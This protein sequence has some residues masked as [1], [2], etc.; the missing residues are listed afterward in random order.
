M[1]AVAETPPKKN[2]Q[3][4]ETPV[5]EEARIH[6]HAA[7]LSFVPSM[8][9]KPSQLHGTP[10]G[11]GQGVSILDS[12]YKG[13]IV[14][15]PIKGETLYGL[16]QRHEINVRNTFVHYESPSDKQ[17]QPQ[18]PPKTV[19]HNFKP[20]GSPRPVVLFSS[21]VEAPQMHVG[22]LSPGA[23]PMP[24]RKAQPG[25]PVQAPTGPTTLRLSDY[26]Q[27]PGPAPPVMTT[28]S[29]G[30]N[31][32]VGVAAPVCPE[33]PQMGYNQVMQGMQT[34]VP[35]FPTVPPL[36]G[37]QMMS[38]PSGVQMMCQPSQMV[39][40]QQGFVATAPMPMNCNQQVDCLNLSSMSLTPI[41][42]NG[43]CG[44]VD[45]QACMQSWQGQAPPPPPPMQT[46]QMG[47][48]VDQSQV[49]SCGVI[50]EEHRMMA[51]QP[52]SISAAHF[53]CAGPRQQAPNCSAVQRPTV[54]CPTMSWRGA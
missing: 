5:K 3:V 42:L 23:S 53:P 13:S 31:Y 54:P 49:Q 21:R 24:Q 50:M 25:P 37:V 2:G 52:L 40:P 48:F 47:P 10:A 4:R 28:T 34:M 46:V 11:K 33:F 9:K 16:P 7:S 26:L 35:G 29:I 19:P 44:Q 20:T 14:M 18:S 30:S 1:M 8:A 39:Q 22:L 32:G 38:Q 12:P 51:P 45:T 17:K 41:N 27:S 43:S 6:G 36:P 15:T